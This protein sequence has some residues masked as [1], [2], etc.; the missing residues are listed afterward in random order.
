M[1]RNHNR[2]RRS[3]GRGRRHRGNQ[4]CQPGLLARIFRNR[5]REG[6]S[7]VSLADLATNVKEIFYAWQNRLKPNSRMIWRNG[8]IVGHSTSWRGPR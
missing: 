3:Q 8:K 2:N 6:S 5:Y 4:R 7:F 1:S